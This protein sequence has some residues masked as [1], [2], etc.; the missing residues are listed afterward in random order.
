MHKIRRYDDY[1]G[2]PIFRDFNVADSIWITI[3]TGT[4]N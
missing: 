3:K 1:K 2:V 4:L